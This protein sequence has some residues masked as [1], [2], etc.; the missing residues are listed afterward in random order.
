MFT[1]KPIQPT[2]E[3]LKKDQL[4]QALVNIVSAYANT[5]K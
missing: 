1:T 5:R 4:V 3:E 2:K